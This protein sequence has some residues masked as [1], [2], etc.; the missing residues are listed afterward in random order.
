MVL[1]W[2]PALAPLLW[3]AQGAHR[4]DS[5][6]TLESGVGLE[7][8]LHRS[9]HPKILTA[10]S[11]THVRLTFLLSVIR[12]LKTIYLCVFIIK[13]LFILMKHLWSSNT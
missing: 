7:S 9:W 6:G 3:A 13:S 11:V 10:D 5:P 12:V 4:H 1:L 2:S 8:L